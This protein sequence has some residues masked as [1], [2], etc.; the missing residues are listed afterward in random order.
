LLMLAVALGAGAYLGVQHLRSRTEPAAAAPTPKPAPARRR[1]PVTAPPTPVAL[2]TTS[3]P[4]RHGTPAVAA[5]SAILVD[6]SS[7]AVLWQKRPHRSR[8]I[9]S[10]TKIMTATLVLER[11]RLNRV[12]RVAP[13]VP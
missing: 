3:R 12:V 5:R 6:A 7:G 4:P 2:L 8:P 13:G 9:A 1:A 11:L 10:T